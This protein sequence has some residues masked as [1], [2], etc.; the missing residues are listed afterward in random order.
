MTS[1][2]SSLSVVIPA[3]NEAGRIQR[4]L[5]ELREV[6]PTLAEWW[7]IR[8]VDDGSSDGTADVV[9]RAAREDGRVLLQAEPHR[10]KG[11]AVRAGLMAAQGNLRF[12][13]DAD[14]SMPAAELRRFMPI[15]PASCDIAI[16]SREVPGARRVG[17]PVHRHRMG[18]VFNGLVKTLALPGIEDTQ[19]GFKMFSA[20]AV[21][22]ICPLMTL[23]GWAFDLEML[24][25]ARRL[26]LRIVEVPI[27]WHYR[28]QSRISPLRDSIR[29]TRDLLKIRVNGRRG[30]YGPAHPARPSR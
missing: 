5:D 18:R 13:C 20:S 27:E 26:G 15:V 16:G 1:T 30:V 3:F 17:E 9:S 10:G 21:R 6:L 25:I 24:F 22:A 8:V 7:E 23:N 11:G 4:T 2:A 14:L 12:M 28:D 19:C 29:M